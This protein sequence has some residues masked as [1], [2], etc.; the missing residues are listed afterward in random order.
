PVSYHNQ[1]DDKSLEYARIKPDYVTRYMTE[2][3]KPQYG[4]DILKADVPVN[5]KY[6]KAALAFEGTSAYSPEEARDRFRKAA[7][8]PRKPFIYL[9]GGVTDEVF[10]ATLELAA[11]AGVGF[12]GVLCGRATWQDGIPAYGKGGAAALEAWLKDRGRRNIEALNQVLRK[13]AK[14]WHDFYG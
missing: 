14:P 9:S 13:G 8:P 10:R 3:S 11:E 5:V 12:A 4:V 1:D 6:V 2:F 7:P